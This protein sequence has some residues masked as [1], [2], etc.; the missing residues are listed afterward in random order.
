[1]GVEIDI[2]DAAKPRIEQGQH[3]EDRIV[4]VAE[5]AGRGGLGVM[6]AAG[7]VVGETAL[8]C[9]RGGQN[10]AAHRRG[11]PLENAGKDGIFQGPDA[12]KPARLMGDL[13]AFVRRL[14]RRDIGRIVEAGERSDI[15]LRVLHDAI[16]QPFQ[17]LTQIDRRFDPGN[18]KRMVP[19]IGRAAVQLA[20]DED[21][22][23]PHS[24][25]NLTCHRVSIHLF[26]YY[27]ILM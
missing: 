15:C 13:A 3:R 1:M 12:V 25:R 6:R 7:R 16:V 23:E 19:A 22:C 24:R 2:E 21:R 11:G 18:R 8:Q 4:E 17:A 20:M 27:K 10:R 9:A 26:S 14:E 5:A